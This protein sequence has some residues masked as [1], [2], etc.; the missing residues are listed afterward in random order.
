MPYYPAN[1]IQTNLFSNGELIRL[2]DLTI[3]TGPYYK[4]SNGQAF[5][6]KDPQAL[7]IHKS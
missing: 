7:D 6:G 3:Y 4:L 1:K 5:A 2:S